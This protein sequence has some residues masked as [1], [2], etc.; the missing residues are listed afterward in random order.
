MATVRLRTVSSAFH[1]TPIPPSPI[2][3][4]TI[5]DRNNRSASTNGPLGTCSEPVDSL[6]AVFGWGAQSPRWLQAGAR[7]MT[8]ADTPSID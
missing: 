8:L 3:S 2:F 1:T 7:K 6:S 5:R 4:A